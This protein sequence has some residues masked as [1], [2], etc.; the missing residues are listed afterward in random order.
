MRKSIFE[1]IYHSN[2]KTI[3]RYAYRLSSNEEMAKDLCQDCFIKLYT[4][5]KSKKP[6][7]QYKNWLYKT[8]SNQYFNQYN[9][10][11][12]FKKY[13]EHNDSENLELKNPEYDLVKNE[14]IEN[15]RKAI[16]QLSQKEQTLILL[17]QDDCT[18]NEMAETTGIKFSSIG[19]TLSR[20][21]EKLGDILKKHEN[22]AMF[23]K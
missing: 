19:K 1:E 4:E 13:L 21:I 2:Y 3:Y 7:K 14:E 15:V 6:I 18:Y 20:T 16:K 5:I 22:Y 9:R 17:Y 10:T 11:K 23:I 8:V 12:N